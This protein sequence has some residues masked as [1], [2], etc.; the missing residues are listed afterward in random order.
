MIVSEGSADS[1]TH[2]KPPVLS[3][4]LDL[5]GRK[6]IVFRKFEHAMVETF[7]EIFF[8][9]EQ[10]KMEVKIINASEECLAVRLFL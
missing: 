1:L 2:F 5:G 9:T 7:S 4:K 10:T 3:E 6:R 8:K